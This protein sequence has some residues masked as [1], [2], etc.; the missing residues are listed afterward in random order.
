[1]RGSHDGVAQSV[2]GS[3]R[4][5]NGGQIVGEAVMGQ[6]VGEEWA[7]DRRGT[8]SMEVVEQAAALTAP[9]HLS[10]LLPTLP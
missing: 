5:G 2:G 6:T 10:P 7:A 3:K 8:G 4:E 9:C 1:M